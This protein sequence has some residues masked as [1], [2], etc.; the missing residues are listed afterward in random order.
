MDPGPSYQ[1][2]KIHIK[3]QKGSGLPPLGELVL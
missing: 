2:I 1:F 3:Q